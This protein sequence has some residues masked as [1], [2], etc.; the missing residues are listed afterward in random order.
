M[1]AVVGQAISVAGTGRT[2]ND[3]IV[4]RVRPPGF[5]RRAVARF[6]RGPAEACRALRSARLLLLSGGRTSFDAARYGAVPERFSLR[7]RAAHEAAQLR[8]ARLH[9][10]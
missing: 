3:T 5:L 2:T 10:A 9:P 4:R 8:P 7:R 1:T 6:L